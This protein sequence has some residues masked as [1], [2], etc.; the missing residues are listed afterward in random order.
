MRPEG[1][2]RVD[3]RVFEL[4]I[5][6]HSDALHDGSGSGVGC[7]GVRHHLLEAQDREPVIE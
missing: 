4:A 3:P 1:M 6:S 5:E 7:G 2:T